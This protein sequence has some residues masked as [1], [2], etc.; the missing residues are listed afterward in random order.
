MPRA[1]ALS[2]GVGRPGVSAVVR[3]LAQEALG[4]V[5]TGTLIRGLSPDPPASVALSGS[6]PSLNS[7]SVMIPGLDAGEL[8]LQLPDIADV[9]NPGAP[10]VVA[11]VASTGKF[12]LAPAVP[13]VGHIWMAPGLPPI[14]LPKL[15][16]IAPSVLPW[17]PA[18]RGKFAGPANV[19][20]CVELGGVVVL[21]TVAIWA[22]PVPQR[23]KKIAATVRNKSRI[24]ASCA[25]FD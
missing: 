20:A 22:K 12:A 11:S 18:G 14:G 8:A 1:P 3:L 16:W 24:C 25:I 19:G 4:V 13:V 2:K 7:D 6:A 5:E 10:F 23:S 21:G 9:P 15:S 17:V